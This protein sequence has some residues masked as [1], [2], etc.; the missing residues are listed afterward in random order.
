V[1]AINDS[2]DFVN[3]QGRLIVMDIES[4]PPKIVRTFDL[5]GKPDSVAVSP[6]ENYI[7]VV[8]ENDR[9]EGLGPLPQ[10]PG[11]FVFVI[12]SS[13]E[14]PT[15]WSFVTILIDNLPGVLFPTDPEPEY[16][17]INHDNIAVITLQENNAIVLIDLVEKTI[18]SS[19]SAGTIDLMQIDILEER[20]ID[21][22]GSQRGNQREP[23]GVVWMNNRYFATADEGDLGPG[24]RGFTVFDKNST[25]VFSAGNDIEFLVTRIG[26]YPEDRSRN[27]GNEPE[28][29]ASGKF[30]RDELLFVASERSSVVIVYNVNDPTKPKF[31][32]VLPAGVSPE[33]VL[34]IPKRNLVVA[35]SEVDDRDAKI[36][37]VLNIYEY[38]FTIPAYP[39]IRSNDRM[40]GTPIPWGALSGLAASKSEARTLYSVEDSFYRKSRMF[41]IDASTTPAV[42]TQEFRILDSNNVLGSVPTD[43]TFTAAKLAALINADKTVNLDLEGIAVAKDGGFWLVSEGSGTVGE[44]SRPILSLNFLI[45]VTAGGVIT[46]VVTLPA[47]VNAIQSRFGFE[48]VAEMT[49]GVTVY[50]VV[51]FQRAWRS[52]HLPRVGLYNTATEQ[53]TFAF[54]PLDLPTSQNGGW[55]GLSDLA[56]TGEDDLLYVL[57]R[58]DQGGPDASIKKI[59]KMIVDPTKFGVTPFNILSKFLVKDLL[60]HL[61]KATNGPVVE[62]VEGLTMTSDGHI[63]VVNDNDGVTDN[64]GETILLEFS[65]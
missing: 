14:D 26:H 59:Y 39:F 13:G 46:K 54:Y 35:S 47:M 56:P 28:S 58:D 55:V 34:S 60:G 19:F 52:E 4:L 29:V 53:W 25:V 41:V 33:G 16:V 22:T 12:N 65:D 44:P 63:W 2:T 10:L 57:E 11:G 49:I 38:G 1:V 5:G 3:Q 62:K 24:G 32:Q 27:K 48:G 40:D 37:G 51:A 20:I 36:R 7:V 43:S 18:V 21:Q 17:S 31:I 23:D 30:G 15:M 64:S 9:D 42:L 8:I 50:V 45:K 61:M 6:D